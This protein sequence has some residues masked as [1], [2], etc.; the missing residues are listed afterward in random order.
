MARR[1]RSYTGERLTVRRMV[2]FT[3]TTAAMSK[4][5]K[6]WRTAKLR[7]FAGKS[8]KPDS[9]DPDVVNHLGWYEATN[10]KRPYPGESKVRLP[11]DFPNLMATPEPDG[12]D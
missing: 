10:F 2:L 12:D 5:E 1:K 4:L 6:A 7:M 11:S 9:E 8:T 3:P